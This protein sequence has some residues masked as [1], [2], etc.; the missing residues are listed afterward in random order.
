MV[1]GDEKEMDAVFHSDSLR[2]PR[3]WPGVI[4]EMPIPVPLGRFSLVGGFSGLLWAGGFGGP[5]LVLHEVL[6][7]PDRLGRRFLH[8]ELRPEDSSR[9]RVGVS[10]VVLREEDT[11]DP[12]RLVVGR[13]GKGLA[14][15]RGDVLLDRVEVG[16]QRAGRATSPPPVCP[17]PPHLAAR[18]TGRATSPPP[19][20]PPPHHLSA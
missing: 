17:P 6:R 11:G 7:E 18:R 15:F 20:C 5:R 4:V 13:H 14:H 1:F 16:A 19:I 10:A 2:N 12:A 3:D 8:R 9:E